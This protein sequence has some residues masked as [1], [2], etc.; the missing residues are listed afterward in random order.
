[1]ILPCEALILCLDLCEKKGVYILVTFFSFF[2]MSV[3]HSS[4]R[5]G[6]PRIK[7]W[8][9][10][11]RTIR[12]DFPTWF[13]YNFE[14]LQA[15]LRR[16]WYYFLQLGNKKEETLFWKK[17]KIY[18]Y[19]ECIKKRGGLQFKGAGPLI[20]WLISFLFLAFK[21]IFI[22]IIVYSFNFKFDRNGNDFFHC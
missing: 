18:I 12:S 17:N 10:R 5:D 15:W 21:P 4:S 6:K 3:Y 8:S 19:S 11:Y 7:D 1:M 13:L 14:K 9:D 2:S 20:R 16:P 22:S